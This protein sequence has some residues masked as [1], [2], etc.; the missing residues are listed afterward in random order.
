[1]ACDNLCGFK[2]NGWHDATCP[3]SDDYVDPET[4][5]TLNASLQK[6]AEIGVYDKIAHRM[7]LTWP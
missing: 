1:M 2:K 7:P 6:T 5:K 3:E 4:I